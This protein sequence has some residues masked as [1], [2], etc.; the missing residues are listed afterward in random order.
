MA[1]TAGSVSGHFIANLINNRWKTVLYAMDNEEKNKILVSI[2]KMPS[3]LD[4]A[5][6]LDYTQDKARF[7][8]HRNRQ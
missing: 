5:K 6:I 4:H 1:T 7:L 2:W 3:N 8:E